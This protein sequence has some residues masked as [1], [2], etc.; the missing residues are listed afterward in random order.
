[1]PWARAQNYSPSNS[2]A[3]DASAQGA[4]KGHVQ[5]DQ[6]LDSH[7]KKGFLSKLFGGKGSNPATNND[8]VYGKTIELDIGMGGAHMY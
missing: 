8:T 2:T 1:L 3:P 6:K 7:P 4:F 5:E